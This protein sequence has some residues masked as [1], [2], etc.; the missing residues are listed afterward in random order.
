M[1]IQR[2]IRGFLGRR[3]FQFLLRAM[4]AREAFDRSSPDID[5]DVVC[6]MAPTVDEEDVEP[7]L[8]GS[9]EHVMSGSHVIVTYE[10]VEGDAGWSLHL[11]AAESVED[12][13]AHIGV[14]PPKLLLMLHDFL[15][16]DA[17]IADILVNAVVQLEFVK[18]VLSH[19]DLFLS[20]VKKMMLL[21]FAGKY[22][23]N[24]K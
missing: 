21:Q 24:K 13:Q 23:V 20:R 8:H 15:V 7:V 17:K 16:Q 18:F 1:Q 3:K 14:P 2:V 4:R 19:I 11:H 12:L 9:F 22:A 5:N 10:F 6:L